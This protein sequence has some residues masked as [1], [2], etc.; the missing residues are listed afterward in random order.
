MMQRS[1]GILLPISSLPSAYGIGCFDKAAYAF[2][3]F[4]KDA[5]QSYW[6]ILPL[7]PTS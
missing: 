7:G 5:G 3:D 6:Q 2:V 1:A 4:L